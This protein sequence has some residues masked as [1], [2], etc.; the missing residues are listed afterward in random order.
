[1]ASGKQT[2]R[3][4]MINMMYLVLT[5][6]LALNI[7]KD[8]LDALTKLNTSLSHT[9]ETVD[10]KNA[11][12]YA[13]FE[14]AV[15]ENA[16]KAGPW[17]D[18][19]VDVQKKSNALFTHIE[20]LKNKLIE[21]S[22][23]IDEETGHPKSLDAREPPANYLLN[24][25][26]ASKLKAEIDAYRDA[27][28]KYTED[29]SMIANINDLFDTG[30]QVVGED[31]IETDWEHAN[32]DHFPLAAILPFLTD[33]QAKVRNSE[34][35][36]ISQLALKINAKDIKVTGVRPVV[37]ATSTYITQGSEYVADVYLAAFDDTQEP[38][39]SVNGT[40][41]DADQIKNG[42][43]KVRFKANKLGE[44][45]WAGVI[46]LKQM[47]QEDKTF[48]VTGSYTVAP[49]TVV[50]SP[51]KMNV[52]YR[53]V[54]NPLEIGVPGVD[55]SKIRVN[56]PG[57]KQISA[58]NYMANVTNVKGKTVKISVSVEQTNE[59]TGKKTMKN[60]GDKEFRI[61]G[62]PPAQGT[63]YKKTTG[64]FSK[65]A[66]KKA[67]VEAIL[68]DFPFDLTLRVVSFEIAIP[69]FPPETI[70]GNTLSS[71]A[72]LRID[73]LKPGSPITFRKIIA[74]GPK[75]LRVDASNISIDV[76]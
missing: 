69:G 39:I 9:V 54:D 8:I 19:A 30:K 17:R 62:V 26:N 36:L 49:P 74:K 70:K 76:N 65:G 41:L 47:G 15:G 68:R 25:K 14:R 59:E 22:G 24:Q 37:Q 67:P 48:D 6:L 11:E 73:K 23:G 46:T 35:D 2:P 5:A 56:G 18:K 64:I 57:V 33:I 28:L 71:D 53:G 55:P 7:S 66:V 42:V 31:K 16:E 10:K 58:G 63:I 50:I 72:K 60:Y 20:S 29:P 45:K 32:F 44:Q 43:G 12:V 1:M 4:K 40:P 51:T 34:S 61:K 52:L 13:A 3:Q 27:I 38:E 75:G 21:V